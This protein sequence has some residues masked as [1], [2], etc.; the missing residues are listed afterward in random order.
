MKRTKRTLVAIVAMMAI[1]CMSLVGCGPKAAPAD[2]SISALFEL[3]AK[4]N[5]APM[6]ELLG[7]ESEEAVNAAFFEED[8]EVDLV[9]EMQTHEALQ[10]VR[11]WEY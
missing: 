7:F 9:A 1:V 11:S 3:Y 8:A 4:N 5:A 10:S 6:Q 2:Q